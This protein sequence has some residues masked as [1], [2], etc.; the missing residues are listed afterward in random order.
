VPDTHF[1]VCQHAKKTKVTSQVTCGTHKNWSAEKRLQCT[2]PPKSHLE[3]ITKED[4]ILLAKR[5]LPEECT[6]FL[7]LQI[8]LLA[9]SR[10]NRYA[11]ELKRFALILYFL[12]PKAYKYSKQTC[13]LPS[14][15]VLHRQLGK[16]EI[17]T[18]LNECIL[19]LL[20]YK[21]KSLKPIQKHCT[22]CVD[23]IALKSHLF[24]NRKLDTIVGI[25]DLGHNN[26]QLMPARNALVFMIK[27]LCGGWKQPVA[28]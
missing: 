6:W 14:I 28:Y 8:G 22:L 9:N 3:H 15:S 17:T 18:A 12:K 26:R 20:E 11:P 5:F 24:Y 10:G 7:N 2:S 27:S 16:F 19:Y 1:N 4:L 13:C 25:K 21:F 23:E